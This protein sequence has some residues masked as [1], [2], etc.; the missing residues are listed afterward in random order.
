MT[1]R[2]LSRGLAWLLAAC[3]FAAPLLL[4]RPALDYARVAIQGQYRFTIS[5]PTGRCYG[6][7]TTRGAA[8]RCYARATATP[9]NRNS[10]P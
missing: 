5:A 1:F 7:Y 8:A 10:S 3:V 9:T 4:V 6:W 2:L